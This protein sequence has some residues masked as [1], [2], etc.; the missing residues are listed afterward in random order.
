MTE[1]KYEYNPEAAIVIVEE[2]FPELEVSK[3]YVLFNMR[4]MWKK[5]QQL[6]MLENQITLLKIDVKGLDKELE[7]RAGEHM[8]LLQEHVGLKGTYD[9][10]LEQYNT[11]RDSAVKYEAIEDI[12]R[13]WDAGE[14]PYMSDEYSDRVHNPS[15]LA[16]DHIQKQILERS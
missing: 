11:I 13:M 9:N 2:H 10:L 3:P 4:E 8:E 12:V 16:M 7:T 15:T 6:E 5:V 14:S 1:D